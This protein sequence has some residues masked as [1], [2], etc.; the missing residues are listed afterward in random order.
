MIFLL[1][2]KLNLISEKSNMLCL[3]I[4]KRIISETTHGGVPSSDNA[5]DF[6]KVIG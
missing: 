3:M 4:I 6:L 2:R 5:K 1:V